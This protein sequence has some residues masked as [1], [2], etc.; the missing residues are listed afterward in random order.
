[1]L[2]AAER[3]GVPPWEVAAGP[4]MWFL[5]WI[6]FENQRAKEEERQA[7]KHG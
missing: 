5:R 6:E 3:W 2:I 4:L 1:V 7:K